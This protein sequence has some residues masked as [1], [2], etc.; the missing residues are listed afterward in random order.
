M[1]HQRE[2]QR[3]HHACRS[4]RVPCRSWMTWTVIGTGYAAP[5]QGHCTIADPLRE[6]CTLSRP[7]V[8]RAHPARFEPQELHSP[9]REPH[10]STR[11]ERSQKSVVRQATGRPSWCRALDIGTKAALGIDTSIGGAP[12]SPRPQESLPLLR[13]AD[14]ARRNTGGRTPADRQAE[15]EMPR[16]KP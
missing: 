12:R 13:P 7:T 3:L 6:A 15:Y 8:S 5:P 2:R 10:F 1:E 14:P 4:S 11:S 9:G 16:R